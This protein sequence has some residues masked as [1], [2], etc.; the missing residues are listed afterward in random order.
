MVVHIQSA[1]SLSASKVAKK[2]IGIAL[3]LALSAC[4][5]STSTTSPTPAPTPTPATS[6]SPTPTPTPTPTPGVAT[7]HT[8]GKYWFDADGQPLTLKG[9]NVG[10]WLLQEFW[11]MGQNGD[12]N[13]QCSLEE[14]LDTR[15]G[16]EERQRLMTLFRDNWIRDRDWDIMADFGF[17]VVRMPFRFNL[18]EDEHNPRTLREDAWHYFDYALEMAEARNMYIIFDLHGAVGSQ[19]WEHHSGCGGKN[20]YWSNAE[21]RDRTEWLWQQI[22]ER[23]KNNTTVAGY[24]L[25]NEAWGTDATTLAE[26]GR[27]LYAAIREID[28]AHT[29]I[30]PDHVTG[31][32]GNGNPSDFGLTNVSFDSHFYP[33]IF[34]WGTPGY[35]V[36]RDW[37]ACGA[38]GDGG[39]CAW[40]EKLTLLDTP[41]LVG[42]FQPWAN[43]GDLSAN[44]GRATFDRYAELGW[45]ATAWSYKVFNNGGGQGSGT[46][47]IVTNDGG[48]FNE[49]LVAANTWVCPD[50]DTNFAEACGASDVQFTPDESY[51]AYFILKAGSQNTLDVSIDGLRLSNDATDVDLLTNGG[52][53]SADGW[54]EWTVSGSP[55]LDY[56]N[57]LNT[58]TNGSGP[59]LYISGAAVNGGIYQAVSLEAGQTYTLSGVFRDHGSIDAWAEVFLIREAPTEGVDVTAAAA[60]PELDFASASL[61]DIEERFQFFGTAEYDVHEELQAAMTSLAPPELFSLPATPTGLTLNVTDSGIELNWNPNSE[62]DLTGYAV[63]RSN[64]PSIGY[65]QI[66][67]NI[68]ATTYID[69]DDSDAARY[70]VVAAQDAEDISYFS[71]Y[72]SSAENTRITIPGTIEAE[73]FSSMDGFELETTSDTGGGYNVGFTDAGDWLEY[74]IDVAQAGNYTVTYR[75]AS[76]AGSTGFAL[77]VDGNT[78]DEQAV[79]STGGWQNW[80][81]VTETIAL[82]AG[83]QTLRVNAIGSSW[84]LNWI[85][86][87]LNE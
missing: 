47:G 86:F 45:A 27:S 31:I 42:E 21:Y 84:N 3:A 36:H 9:L 78:I 18:I 8:V 66:A 43:L 38:D 62:I 76:L 39:V 74:N 65:M 60:M 33:G 58:P 17:N 85:S 69:T 22:A 67:Q 5:G 16:L 24:G 4:S 54:N 87:S 49:N 53:G 71:D 55:T 23:Y 75:L 51:T 37:L 57:T 25:L 46:W 41:I 6:P 34:G 61:A 63:Y 29:I 72:V 56:N 82:E 77:L 70:Y 80:V 10:N 7:V 1:R 14:T 30:L 35:E 13:D 83:E 19:G 2:A 15:F 11:M 59:A 44:I 79:S 52:F 64:I 12:V 81:D 73:A 32:D 48:A 26:E 20:E 40:D 68:S 28:S 50:W